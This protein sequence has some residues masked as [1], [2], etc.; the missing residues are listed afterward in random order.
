MRDVSYRKLT[1]AVGMCSW[2]KGDD[3]ARKRTQMWNVLHNGACCQN[4][5]EQD[6]RMLS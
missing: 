6:D 3:V 2:R 1:L 4:K 5:E